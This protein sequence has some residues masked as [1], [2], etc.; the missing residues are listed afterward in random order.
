MQVPGSHGSNSPQSKKSTSRDK[1]KRTYKKLPK[2]G[3]REAVLLKKENEMIDIR[4]RIINL[5]SDTPKMRTEE[6]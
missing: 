2:K 1:V 5:V 3:D 6:S 4:N